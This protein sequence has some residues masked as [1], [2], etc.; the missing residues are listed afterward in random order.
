MHNNVLGL[1]ASVIIILVNIIVIGNN[2][3]LRYTNKGN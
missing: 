1:A 3:I 2:A